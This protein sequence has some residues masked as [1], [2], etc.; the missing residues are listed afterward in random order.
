MTGAALAPG[1][2][3]DAPPRWAVAA[4]PCCGV[5]G[6][7]GPALAA[8]A[9]GDGAGGNPPATGAAGADV[10]GSMA[11]GADPAGAAVPTG[12]GGGADA[13]CGAL[14]ALCAICAPTL[15]AVFSALAVAAT[16]PVPIRA[17]VSAIPAPVEAPLSARPT[18]DVAVP[19]PAPELAPLPG[20][21]AGVPVPDT[22]DGDPDDAGAP[23]DAG[24]P[25]D[26]DIGRIADPNTDAGLPAPDELPPPV[27]GADAAGGT[28]DVPAL[29]GSPWEPAVAASL[30]LTS[31]GNRLESCAALDSVGSSAWRVPGI[32]SLS[33]S[34]PSLNVS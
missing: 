16:A 9:A 27:E 8:A 12:P 31:S 13:G 32:R 29:P 21:A 19:F 22:P 20:W 33:G 28:P 11:S 23:E 18:L 4:G 5:P 34:V 30:A 3:A 26:E 1:P 17:E 24:D 14:V 15:P 10:G 25:A 6:I 2:P 7:P